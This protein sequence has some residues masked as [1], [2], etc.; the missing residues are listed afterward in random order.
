[1][2]ALTVLE[3]NP[4]MV[5]ANVPL[6]DAIADL[7][8][9]EQLRPRMVRLSRLSERASDTDTALG[10][11]VMT[12]ALQGY[13]LLKLT[14]RTEGLDPLR[15]E[16]GVRFAKSS[17]RAVLPVPVTPVPAPQAEPLPEAKAA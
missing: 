3:Q 15:K 11:D 9:L 8:A 4:Q 14:G 13:S 5:P 2:I 6:A 17:R 12:V 7:N 1:M 10:A 16:L